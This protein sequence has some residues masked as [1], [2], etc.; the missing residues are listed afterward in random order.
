MDEFVGDI[1]DTLS[2]RKAL[3]GS[4]PS[5]A[6][7]GPNDYTGV[8]SKQKETQ[9]DIL[10]T[11]AKDELDKQIQSQIAAIRDE[12]SRE[13]PVLYTYRQQGMSEAQ[14][15]AKLDEQA[16]LKARASV[17]RALLDQEAQ[18]DGFPHSAP[19]AAENSTA[20]QRHYINEAFFA[21]DEELK[22][23]LIEQMRANITLRSL[24]HLK[25][26]DRIDARDRERSLRA[27][28]KAAASDRE[29][30]AAARK[31]LG[32]EAA[33]M[34]VDPNQNVTNILADMVDVHKREAEIVGPDGSTDDIIDTTGQVVPSKSLPAK[35]E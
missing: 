3:E 24:L 1:L 31:T 20:L 23:S 13:A 14:I 10:D 34:G 35:T 30:I 19:R 28:R 4:K 17:R 6:K 21:S 32:Q 9:P 8:Y 22:P 5:P 27:M 26:D 12:L 2:D 11:L 29:H 18:Q 7:E 25:V 33:K 16:E 15:N